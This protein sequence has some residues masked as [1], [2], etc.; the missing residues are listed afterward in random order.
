MTSSGEAIIEALIV[1]DVISDF[2]HEDGDRLLAS[3]RERAAN[4]EQAL[5]HA[6]ARNVNVIYVNDAHGR[7][8]GER[9]AHVEHALAAA[10]GEVV[11]RIAPR[12]GDDFLFKGAYSAFDGTPLRSILAERDVGR[13]VLT[14][15]ATEMCV[16][17]TAISAREGKL[18][19]TVLADA[20]ATID[21]GNETTALDYLARVTGSVIASVE[22]WRSRESAV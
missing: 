8:D 6:R 3:L 4:L 1:L 16:A 12:E 11:R 14:G 21:A 18:Q 5:A 13:V 10:G 9:S 22:S 7:W 19:V 17:Q 20:C 2:A 15:A